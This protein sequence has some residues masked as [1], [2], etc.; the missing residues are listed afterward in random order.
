MAW[1]AFIWNDPLSFLLLFLTTYWTTALLLFQF[2]SFTK[3]D[4]WP[5]T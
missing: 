2:F 4:T 1:I 5:E 3:E